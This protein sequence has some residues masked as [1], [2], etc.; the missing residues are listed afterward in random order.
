MN[1][2]FLSARDYCPVPTSGCA[3]A[4]EVRF[5]FTDEKAEMGFPLSQWGEDA[6]RVALRALPY[7]AWHGHTD[8]RRAEVDSDRVLTFYPEDFSAQD[9]RWAWEQYHEAKHLKATRVVRWVIIWRWNW[10]LLAL[11]A[12]L[13][14]G[15][16]IGMVA[17]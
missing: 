11:G 7:L 1:M 2:Q 9:V 10:R 3:G 5:F 14:L 8:W 16:L 15:V 12:A 4:R 17:K 6:L 13:G